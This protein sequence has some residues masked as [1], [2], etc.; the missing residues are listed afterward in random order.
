MEAQAPLVN[1]RFASMDATRQWTLRTNGRSAPMD[2]PHQWTLRTN[3]RSAS[4][5]AS[6]QWTSRLCKRCELVVHARGRV[7]SFNIFSR[8]F[9]LNNIDFFR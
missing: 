3:G 9:R 6:R 5:D 1:G 2:A 4:M 8:N 7:P